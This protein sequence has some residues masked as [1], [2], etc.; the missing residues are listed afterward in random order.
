MGKETAIKT[1][2]KDIDLLSFAL[3]NMDLL[4]DDEQF[5]FPVKMSISTGLDSATVHIDIPYTIEYLR[6]YRR[7]MG[8][9]WKVESGWC[10]TQLLSGVCRHKSYIR[11]E[12]SPDGHD[13]LNPFI[14]MITVDPR[15]DKSVCHIEQDGVKEVPI[16]K[17]VCE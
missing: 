11:P 9:G 10:T 3:E 5:D 4:P 16:W 2:Q 14:V 8:P 1:T 17:V 6:Q 13:Y 12:F 15:M 7:A